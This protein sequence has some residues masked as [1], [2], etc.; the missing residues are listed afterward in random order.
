MYRRF[1][2]ADRIYECDSRTDKNV[3]RYNKTENLLLLHNSF[4]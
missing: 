2:A 4:S 1:N 3:A